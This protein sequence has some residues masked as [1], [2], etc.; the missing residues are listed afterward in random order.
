LSKVG[1]HFNEVGAF[2]RGIWRYWRR[3]ESAP[4]SNFIIQKLFAV[5]NGRSND[6][7]F[8]LLESKR[9]EANLKLGWSGPSLLS[10]AGVHDPTIAGVVRTLREDG[11]VVIPPRLK[12]ETVKNLYD[13]ALSCTL[14]TANY[15]PPAP[16]HV[17][18][19]TKSVN[20]GTAN[21]IDPTQ[22]RYSL[23]MVPRPTLLD[24]HNVQRL[25]CD[26]Y[27]LAVATGYLGVFPIITKPDMWWDTTSCLKGV[28]P[29]H[30]TWIQGACGGSRLA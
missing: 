10:D 6:L 26:P 20:V 23:Y 9:K 15:G 22:P 14:N 17:V 30:F 13:M 27:L 11:V 28:D 7:L 5:T 1:R 29:A 18:G 4:E 19:Q 8:R 24:N 16:N 3:G 25:L 21:G 12:D 2:G